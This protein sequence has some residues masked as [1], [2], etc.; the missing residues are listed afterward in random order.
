MSLCAMHSYR[1]YS[2]R[3]APYRTGCAPIR[4]SESWRTGPCTQITA[5]RV[6][7]SSQWPVLAPHCTTR[8]SAAHGAHQ[9]A[10]CEACG[11]STSLNTG[12]YGLEAAGAALGH[13]TRV[14]STR[15]EYPNGCAPLRVPENLART[16]VT[17]VL[18]L[19]QISV[20]NLSGCQKAVNTMAIDM[21]IPATLL[22]LRS[23][24]LMPAVTGPLHMGHNAPAVMMGCAQP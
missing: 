22:H 5:E 2:V 15:C 1:R 4:V 17:M 24:M 8:A 6:C 9:Q 20:H 11:H 14:P 3:T 10:Y 7:T 23:H 13:R 12:T 18:C 21:I 19:G 16:A